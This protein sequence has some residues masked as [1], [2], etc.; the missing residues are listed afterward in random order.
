MVDRR[1]TG[2]SGVPGGA[3]RWGS[4]LT[5]G[6]LRPFGE[7]L[8]RRSGRVHEVSFTR[9]WTLGG[10][11]GGSAE[12]EA[13]PEMIVHAGVAAVVRA[14]GRDLGWRERMGAAQRVGLVAAAC[15]VA[16][17]I[18]VAVAAVLVL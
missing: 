18:A 10:P 16:I 7:Q 6:A 3:V 17:A 2:Q 15:G 8:R 5:D 4:E 14:V 12:P 11:A 1:Q 13:P 9:T